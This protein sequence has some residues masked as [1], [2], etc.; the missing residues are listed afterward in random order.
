MTRETDAE[1]NE[2]QAAIVEDMQ[3]LR[4]HDERRPTPYD[5]IQLLRADLEQTRARLITAQS[6]IWHMQLV[7]PSLRNVHGGEKCGALFH[8]RYHHCSHCRIR[9]W[10][11]EHAE[12][13]EGFK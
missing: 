7:I 11:A 13:V 1:W 2:R 3:C 9:E 6:A 5:T 12:K 8:S 10:L 4:S